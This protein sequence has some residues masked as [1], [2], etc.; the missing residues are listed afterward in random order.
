MHA[1][2]TAIFV[3]CVLART[4]NSNDRLEAYPTL[5]LFLRRFVR[6]AASVD[7]PLDL[8]LAFGAWDFSATFFGTFGNEIF[9][10]Q[11]EFY[12]FRNFSTNVRAD[13]LTDSWTPELLDN[14]KYPILDQNDTFSGQQIS[15]YYI[16]DGSY[17]RL[18]N[19][20]IGYRLPESLIPGTRVYV[21]AENLFTLT[22]YS[23]LDPA[24]P[25]ANIGGSGGDIRDQY[26]GVHRGAYPSNMVI[27]FGFNATF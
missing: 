17:I 6:F 2:G 1:P 23:G 13:L 18:R 5:L 24:L 27:S 25:A 16:E 19:V 4:G 11:K 7:Q 10:V 20:Q 9:D 21:Q 3:G 14:A 22:G 15:D 8:G 12:V 26:R